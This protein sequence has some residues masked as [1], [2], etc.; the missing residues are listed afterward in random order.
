MAKACQV[1]EVDVSI[2]NNN[3][4]CNSVHTNLEFNFFLV[5]YVFFHDHNS[6]L[7]TDRAVVESIC[8]VSKHFGDEDFSQK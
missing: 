4:R 8:D 1:S 5:S 2:F 6:F 3:Q 7:S